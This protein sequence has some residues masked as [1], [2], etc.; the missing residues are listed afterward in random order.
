MEKIDSK[1]DYVVASRSNYGT[2]FKRKC[3]FCKN[4]VY[5]MEKTVKY[6]KKISKKSKKKKYICFDC[7]TQRYDEKEHKLMPTPESVKM[8]GISKSEIRKFTKILV[9]AEKEEKK[10]IAIAG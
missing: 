2:S 7:F 6:A 5:P 8:L 1:Y 3:V 9:E 10:I 4:P